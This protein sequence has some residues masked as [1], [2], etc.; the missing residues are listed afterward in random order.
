MKKLVFVIVASVILSGCYKI[1]L[2]NG[3]RPLAASYKQGEWHHDGVIGLVEFSEPVDMAN[4]CGGKN[5]E[6]V[7]VHQTFV[8]GLVSGVTYS[9]YNPWDVAYSCR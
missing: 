6:S 7:K 1:T 3:A 8:Q 2:Q 5:W 9:L 4:R